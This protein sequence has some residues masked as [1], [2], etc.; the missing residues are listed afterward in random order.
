MERWWGKKK[1]ENCACENRKKKKSY[2]QKLLKRQ[3][4]QFLQEHE[5]S[6]VK[7]NHLQVTMRREKKKVAQK[8]LATQM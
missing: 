8:P 2:F 3:S 4:Q 5:H 1:R 7:F 6:M